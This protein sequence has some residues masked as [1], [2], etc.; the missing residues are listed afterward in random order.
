MSSIQLDK[1]GDIGA[2]MSCCSRCGEPNGEI[3]LLGNKNYTAYCSGC[4]KDIV[5]VTKRARKCPN[6][7]SHSLKDHK[8]IPKYE[9]L[10]RG[11]CKECTSEIDKYVQIVTDGGIYWKCTDC[12]NNGVIKAHA[13]VS[14]MVRK[15][16]NIAA[17]GA[18]GIE[19][20]KN[21]CPTCK[22]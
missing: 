11:I 8:V 5:G 14:K 12:G 16:M 17:P 15:E 21:E 13:E 18:C 7:N 2:H 20:D 4:S 19:L 1:D 22:E 3:V 6:C 10:P 9:T